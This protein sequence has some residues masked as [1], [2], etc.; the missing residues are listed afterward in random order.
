MKTNSTHITRI[1]LVFLLSESI[2]VHNVHGF[3]SN[4]ILQ[5]V[6]IQTNESDSGSKM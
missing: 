3:K 5:V 1:S 6:Y 4:S 2:G